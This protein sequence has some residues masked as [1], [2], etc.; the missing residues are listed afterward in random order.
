[1][2]KGLIKEKAVFM[3]YL[4][5]SLTFISGVALKEVSAEEE[6]K[7]MAC[8]E[9]TISGDNC[10]Y[11]SVEN[12]NQDYNIETFKKCEDTTYCALGCCVTDEGSCSKQT[13]KAA[14][15]LQGF[16]WVADA[17]CSSVQECKKGCCVLGG[18]TCSYVTEQRCDIM[19]ENYP[20]LDKDFRQSGS[21]FEC[22]AICRS[23]DRGCCVKDDSCTWG[24]RGNC[25]LPDGVGGNGF[26]KDVFCSNQNL[27]CEC[28]RHYRKG[29][30]DGEED[31]YW[32]DSCGNPEDVAEDCDYTYKSSI[33]S[34]ADSFH[35]EA[36]CK[37]VNCITTWED[38]TST[39]PQNGK[40]RLNGE[41]WCSYDAKVGPTFDVVGSRHY[42][43]ICINGQEIVEP[44]KDYRE[45][46][47]TSITATDAPQ[48]EMKVAQCKPNRWKDCTT[49]CNTAK[50]AKDE[51]E[52]KIRMKEDKQC[53]ER[54]DL[55]DCEWIS[56]DEN[57]GL[58]IPLVA[59]GLKFWSD[60]ENQQT[61]DASAVEECEKGTY[62]AKAKWGRKKLDVT[63]KWECKNNCDVYKDEFLQTRNQFCRS[64]GDC[65][66]HYNYLGKFTNDGSIRTWEKDPVGNPKI[67]VD[68]EMAGNFL[69]KWKQ[70]GN[71]LDFGKFSMQDY[72]GKLGGI[73]GYE[74]AISGGVIGGTIALVGLGMVAYVAILE[75]IAAPVL[76]SAS[77][78]VIGWVIAAI[79]VIIAALTIAFTWPE[80]EDR[81]V[82]VTCQPWQPPPGGDDCSKCDENP[83]KPCSEYRCRSLGAN[84]RFIAENEGTGRETCINANPKDVEKP[85]IKPHPES[86]KVVSKRNDITQQY[87]ISSTPSGYKI[88]PEV[89]AFSK[90]SFGIQ[91][92]EPSQ[93]YY[94]T[95]FKDKYL[96]TDYT[97]PMPDTFYD[98]VHN[99]TYNNLQPDT[100][101]KFYIAC[102][103]SQ[104]NPKDDEYVTPY[105]IEFK[106]DNSPDLDV[107]YIVST[108]LPKNNKIAHNKNSTPIMVYVDEVSEFDCKISTHDQD[109]ELMETEMGCAQNPPESLYSSYNYC[110]ALVNVSEGANTYY[111]RCQDHPVNSEPNTNTESYVVQF[112]KTPPLEIIAKGPSGELYD[113]NITMF[114]QVSGGADGT[115]SC[116]Y[117][118]DKVSG[119]FGVTN[120]SK[121]ENVFTDLPPGQYNFNIRCTDYVENV[122]LTEI[123]F[124][125]IRDYDAPFVTS[126]KKSG[127]NIIVKL[128]EP[129][130]CEYMNS[131]F[132]FGQGKTSAINSDIHSLSGEGSYTLICKDLFDNI[133][134]P[135]NIVPYLPRIKVV[136]KSVLPT[137]P[138]APTSTP[139]NVKTIGS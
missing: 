29:C 18:A 16:K 128:N 119:A 60:D 19:L 104:P 68:E 122:A 44:C 15:E 127:D 87:T 35:E 105:I 30:L 88:N 98:S 9:Q 100:E 139:S 132:V 135:V 93:C 59:P 7:D 55:R 96:F 74:G 108:Y 31:V 56:E 24:T 22:T 23:A 72:W 46:I 111:I 32:F 82:T 120:T 45:E 26:Y 121:N 124:T 76:V 84:C 103:D 54:S 25:G 137:I 131:S 92:N 51:E 66:A 58:C 91:T 112:E 6:L 61:P 11:T 49:T 99:I 28:E 37:S 107:P 80:T 48:G 71:A 41:S 50:D 138:N 81:T 38:P 53:C 89:P 40:T 126:L 14:C 136:K 20:E 118:S 39:D 65:G 5:I 95:E 109:Y 36:Y 57:N 78:P 79:G 101:Y 94:T 86:L 115:A 10:V 117:D 1:M 133:M 83:M 114:V 33:C 134:N 75:A 21:E 85:V 8:C 47:C 123:N 97:S 2:K 42:R 102:R 4:I 43:H 69:E 64:L 125:S 12:C 110:A 17:E 90:V 129:A 106:T 113:K 63:S 116:T 27:N 67:R 70:A 34:E 77:I 13:S 3:I 73:R 52:Q 62:E 130:T